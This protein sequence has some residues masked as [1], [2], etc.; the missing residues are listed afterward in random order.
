MT[1]VRRSRDGESCVRQLGLGDGLMGEGVDLVRWRQSGACTGGCMGADPC[2]GK[3]L[4]ELAGKEAAGDARACRT[5]QEKGAGLGCSN[6]KEGQASK[7]GPALCLATGPGL[8]A[9]CCGPYPGSFWA[10][11]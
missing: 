5:D 4:H 7:P 11:I 3:E 1:L 10:K 2:M 6:R 8:L 9:C